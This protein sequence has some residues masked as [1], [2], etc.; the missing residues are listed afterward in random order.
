MLAVGMGLGVATFAPLFA[1]VLLARS[2]RLKPTVSRGMAALGVSFAFAMA[3]FALV[4]MSVPQDF[5]VVAVGFLMGFLVMW[6]VL[7]AKTM[8][9]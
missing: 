4:W 1:V 7:A 6:A 3:A 2:G 8:S 5:P 9:H